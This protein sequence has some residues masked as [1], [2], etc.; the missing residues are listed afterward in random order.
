VELPTRVQSLVLY[1]CVP[2]SV[3]ETV[4]MVPWPPKKHARVSFLPVLGL[5]VPFL[6]TKVNRVSL[7]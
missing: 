7:P 2:T 1:G 4:Q 5:V 3:V 6:K